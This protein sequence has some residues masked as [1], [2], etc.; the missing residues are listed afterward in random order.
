MLSRT[1]PRK[2]CRTTVVI[3]SPTRAESNDQ[4]DESNKRIPSVEEF[5]A[6]FDEQAASCLENAYLTDHEMI[7]SVDDESV[8]TTLCEDVFSLVNIQVDLLHEYLLVKKLSTTE[9]GQS[10]IL[11]ALLCIVRHLH[12]LQMQHRDRFLLDLESSCAAANDFMRMIE[13]F[14]ELLESVHRRYPR[15][16]LLLMNHSSKSEEDAAK[17]EQLEVES[18]DLVALYGNDAVYSVQRSQIFVMKTIQ[19]SSI[20]QDLF[21][22]EWEVD[23]VYNEVALAIVKTVEDFLYDY[24]DHLSN[25]FLYGKIVG[26]LVRSIV[27]FYV[28]C[29]LRKADH[30]RRRKRRGKRF[31]PVESPFVSP[32]RAVLRMMYDIE[33]FRSYFHNLVNQLPELARLVDEELSV[34]VII[35][36][37]LILAIDNANVSAVEELTVVLHKRTGATVHVTRYIM[38]DLW[39]LVARHR[40]QGRI[41][42]DTLQLLEGE[43]QLVS[44]NLDQRQHEQSGP[45]S[46][47]HL[48]GL[49]LKEVL[50]QFYEGRLV[51]DSI[52]PCGPC[53]DL[54][55]TAQSLHGAKSS[56]GKCSPSQPRD[57]P[58]GIASIFNLDFLNIPKDEEV[59]ETS[60]DG[61][62]VFPNFN[63][64]DVPLT[65]TSNLQSIDQSARPSKEEHEHMLI[66]LREKLC[67]NLKLHN[68]RFIARYAAIGFDQRLTEINGWGETF[69]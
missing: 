40:E 8:F 53:L 6:R 65:K 30:I 16:K 10:V 13:C 12:R 49:R 66:T 68:I 28:Q 43:L 20:P 22:V 24:H 46:R 25:S 69:R 60:S 51:Q 29:L 42:H 44:D 15:L 35:H 34:L 21:S 37:C 54:V 11:V 48:P 26:A 45:R 36:E 23:F 56:V 58:T 59:K 64:T 17:L 52:R 9:D 55:Q 47:D 57:S 33:V 67:A 4:A 27:S 39:L 7:R 41:L 2:D 38:K 50:E 3:P 18:S 31:G 19:Q 5:L 32:G 62:L 1:P 63:F 61:R 14:D